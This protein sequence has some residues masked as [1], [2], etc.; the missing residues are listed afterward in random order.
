MAD[1]KNPLSGPEGAAAVYGPQKGV[2]PH[3]VAVLDRGL[4][5][6]ATLLGGAPES[7]GTG[8]A[9]GTAYGLAAAWNARL[10]SGA[11]AMADLL[12]LRPRTRRRRPAD[13]R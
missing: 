10:V 13:H 7:P 8:A 11:A 2:E 6:L 9:G 1:V 12:A 3:D 4:T 5:Q